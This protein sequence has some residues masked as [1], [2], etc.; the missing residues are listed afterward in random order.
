MMRRLYVPFSL[1]LFALG[2]G[3][4]GA[5][6]SKAPSTPAPAQA[7]APSPTLPPLVSSNGQ[8]MA[9]PPA[10]TAGIEA[11][12]PPAASAEMEWTLPAGW[13]EVTPSSP[14]RRAQ[15]RVPGK[16]GDG[17]CAV[18][19]FG[20]GQGGDPMSNAKRWAGQFKRPDGSPALGDMKTTEMTAGKRSVLLVQ[21]S[22]TYDGGM[23][24]T[25]A[26]STPKPGY[27]LLGAIVEGPD[28]N[29]FFKLTGP[30]ATVRE[31]HDAFLGLLK[32]LK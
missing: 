31:Q 2:C 14:M 26:P 13:E 29:W 16:A 17:E 5:V 20:P 27:A 3:D 24:M 15:Y 11:P 9:Q 6:S 8:A 10:Q 1:A 7:S 25:S 18:F 23:T 4:Q 12:A 22:G 30:E 21:V 28:A 19:Y 32:S